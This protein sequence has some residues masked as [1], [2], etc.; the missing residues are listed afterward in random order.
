ME[1]VKK[2]LSDKVNFEQWSKRNEKLVMRIFQEGYRGSADKQ[3]STKSIKTGCVGVFK[4]GKETHVPK[5]KQEDK[6]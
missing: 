1:V 3:P 5:N 4:N 6:W 2:V